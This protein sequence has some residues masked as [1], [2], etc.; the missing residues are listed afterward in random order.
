MWKIG[1]RWIL[2]REDYR[3]IQERVH[4]GEHPAEVAKDFYISEFEARKISGT[5]QA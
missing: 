4:S 1:N 2:E 3:E 5:L